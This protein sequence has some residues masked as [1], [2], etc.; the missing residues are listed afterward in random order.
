MAKQPSKIKHPMKLINIRQKGIL[1]GIG[2]QSIRAIFYHFLVIDVSSEASTNQKEAHEPSENVTATFLFVSFLVV[3]MFFVRVSVFFFLAISCQALHRRS[4]GASD[5]VAAHLASVTNV[6]FLSIGKCIAQRVEN[7]F[8]FQPLPGN[9]QTW[10]V[11]DVNSWALVDAPVSRQIEGVF[12][13]R[14]GFVFVRISA[15]RK[16]RLNA[17]L[18]D[19]RVLIGV[20]DALVNREIILIPAKIV[21][22]INVI[23]VNFG[24]LVVLVDA[25]SPQ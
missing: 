16:A 19:A 13:Q 12:Q 21:E 11:I 10:L 1:Q 3:V 6:G 8:G 2:T 9:H 22:V 7:S 15:V 5:G 23:P 18:V 14:I 25:Q 20:I 17:L 4:L 24:V